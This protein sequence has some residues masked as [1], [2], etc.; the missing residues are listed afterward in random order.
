MHDLPRR[1]V[2]VNVA[3]FTVYVVDGDWPI[4]ESRAVVGKPFTQTPIFRAD[5]TYIVLN[6]TW[7]VPPGIMRNEIVPGMRRDPRYLAKK[8]LRWQDGK[9]VQPA[10][11]RNALGRIK[12]MFPN[13]HAVYL[14]DT[15]SRALFDEPTRIFSHGCIRVQKPV[16]LAALAL[17]DPAWEVARLDE[18]IATSRTQTIKLNR[19]VPVLVL[20]WTATVGESGLVYLLD[21]PYKRDQAALAALDAPFSVRDPR[22]LVPATGTF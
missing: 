21:D 16:E 20:Y 2:L 17:D 9:V 8:G 3:G 14:H 13:P 11:P 1:F 12:L 18:A 7:T 5:M 6:P 22:A 15:P 4:W 10:G 19:T